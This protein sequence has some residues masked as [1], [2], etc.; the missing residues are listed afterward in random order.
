MRE[1]TAELLQLMKAL[2]AADRKKKSLFFSRFEVVLL[3]GSVTLILS[4]ITW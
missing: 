1:V 2:A 3:H 4:P